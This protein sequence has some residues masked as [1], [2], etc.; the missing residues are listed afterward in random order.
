VYWYVIEHQV[1]NEMLMLSCVAARSH[2]EAIEVAKEDQID[3]ITNMFKVPDPDMTLERL[4]D[5]IMGVLES[6]GHDPT[7][8]ENF[9]RLAELIGGAAQ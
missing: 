7:E 2:D 3:N 8:V 6:E 9:R 4:N 1:D 5:L